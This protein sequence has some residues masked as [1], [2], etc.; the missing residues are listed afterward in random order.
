MQ[1]QEGL[2]LGWE[3]REEMNSGG[4]TQPEVWGGREQ[5]KAFPFLLPTFCS[6]DFLGI[7]ILMAKG[8]S[9]QN[10]SGTL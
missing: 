6:L 3:K 1:G 5:A 8:P 9:Q 10:P 7:M 4:S 2:K